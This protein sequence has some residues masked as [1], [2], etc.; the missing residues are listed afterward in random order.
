MWRMNLNWEGKTLEAVKYLRGHCSNAGTKWEG[1]ELEGD[2][3]NREMWETLR[4]KSQQ[5][6]RTN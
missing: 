6:L 1:P 2:Q 5:D 4:T 3:A